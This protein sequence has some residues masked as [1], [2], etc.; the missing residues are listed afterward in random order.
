MSGKIDP[1][2]RGKAV[3]QIFGALII[4][5]LVLSITVLY[6]LTAHIKP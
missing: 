1:Q 4:G 2:K 5:M 6:Q 3:A